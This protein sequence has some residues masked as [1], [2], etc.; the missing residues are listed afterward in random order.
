MHPRAYQPLLRGCV[1]VCR[2][3]LKEMENNRDM[4]RRG[5]TMRGALL[6]AGMVCCQGSPSSCM[7]VSDVSAF[8]PAQA[9]QARLVYPDLSAALHAAVR[10]CTCPFSRPL[11]TP[12]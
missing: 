5:G 8:T 7:C 1:P 9:H 11:K 6:P 10:T 12:L 2:R 3:F 4:K